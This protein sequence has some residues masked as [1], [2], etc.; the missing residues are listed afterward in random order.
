MTSAVATYDWV[1]T[2]L[3]QIV[4]T[5]AA[6]LTGHRAVNATL[7]TTYTAPHDY[8]SADILAGSGLAYLRGRDESAILENLLR[9][10]SYFPARKGERPPVVD[11]GDPI[12]RPVGEDLAQLIPGKGKPF[13]IRPVL[14]TVLDQGFQGGFFEV[15]KDWGP[16]VVTGFGRLGGD[17]VAIIA[18]QPKPDSPPEGSGRGPFYGSTLDRESAEKFAEFVELANQLGM[19]LLLDPAFAG[20]MPDDRNV[21]GRVYKAGRD[22]VYNLANYQHPIVMWA[23]PF[24]EWWGGAVAVTGKRINPDNMVIFADL[25]GA[26]GILGAIGAM[27]IPMV[28][29]EIENL[30][31]QD[32]RII[33]LNEKIRNAETREDQDRLTG[34]LK[35]MT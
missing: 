5:A 25:Q 1:L 27:E 9:L 31:S 7:G 28:S 26:M 16:A 24:F 17:T 21:K 18:P 10:L 30:V 4:E 22:M 15:A 34:E 13:D 8:S 2:V 20:F 12:D 11:T 3:T 14:N 29:R 33:E 19:P 35:T 32:P 6:A 23:H